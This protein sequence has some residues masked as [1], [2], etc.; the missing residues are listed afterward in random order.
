MIARLFVAFLLKAFIVGD[1][2]FGKRR[3]RNKTAANV[4]QAVALQQ[5]L[6][7]HGC[8]AEAQEV[9]NEWRRQTPRDL[10]LAQLHAGHADCQLHLYEH[11]DGQYMHSVISEL[12]EAIDIIDE[13]RA[14]EA[15]TDHTLKLAVRII[16]QVKALCAEAQK[17]SGELARRMPV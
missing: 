9:I 6:R 17:R 15:S 16:E 14:D 12:S 11:S 5:S 3:Y 10:S 1:F 2:L 4:K 8:Y 7:K 13:V